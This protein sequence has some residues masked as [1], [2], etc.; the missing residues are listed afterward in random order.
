LGEII[1][2]GVRAIR[3]RLVDVDD[4]RGRSGIVPVL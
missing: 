4:W 3:E 2:C 1:N